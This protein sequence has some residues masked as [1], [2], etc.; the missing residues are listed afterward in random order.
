MRSYTEFRDLSSLTDIERA[1]NAE[2]LLIDFQKKLVA[3]INRNFDAVLKSLHQQVQSQGQKAS[4]INKAKD[5]WRK[6][7]SIPQP[8]QPTPQSRMP[9]HF[10][11]EMAP[12]ADQEII[13]ELT[14]L[15]EGPAEAAAEEAVKQVM[16][17]KQRLLT[18]LDK[19]FKTLISRM[20]QQPTQQTVGTKFDPKLV[21]RSYIGAD[22]DADDRFQTKT[23]IMSPPSD[24]ATGYK[25]S[26][27]A[28]PKRTPE[29]TPD[30]TEPTWHIRP[31]D[32]PTADKLAATGRMVGG[33]AEKEAQAAADAE[34][35]ADSVT[36]VTRKSVIPIH[37]RQRVKSD[38]NKGDTTKRF[39]KVFEPLGEER[40]NRLKSWFNR[41]NNNQQISFIDEFFAGGGGDPRNEKLLNHKKFPE[42]INWLS[43]YPHGVWGQIGKVMTSYAL[44]S[45]EDFDSHVMGVLPG[46][47]KMEKPEIAPQKIKKGKNK[48]PEDKTESIFEK[49]RILVERLRRQRLEG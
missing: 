48:N 33:N 37:M 26:D 38:F 4:W 15:M 43:Y 34:K 21:S 25:A 1:T 6:A 11:M 30:S 32:T 2:K 47:K 45:Q 42:I 39:N 41:L 14:L 27:I 44:N 5:W 17:L 36:P 23:H 40:Q 29:R 8:T 7:W 20:R 10:V 24:I 28:T 31:D 13:N 16:G 3:L 35:E 22:A 9:E 18:D 19:M 46:V 12:F 49:R